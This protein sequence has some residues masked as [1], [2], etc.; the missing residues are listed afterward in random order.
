MFV[1]VAMFCESFQGVSIKVWQIWQIQILLLVTMVT[2]NHGWEPAN[3]NH[4]PP[5][6]PYDFTKVINAWSW[7]LLCGYAVHWTARWGFT[8]CRRRMG[9]VMS[10]GGD[11]DDMLKQ[12]L[13]ALFSF[14]EFPWTSCECP[15]MKLISLSHPEI[16][17]I[18]ASSTTVQHKSRIWPSPIL[19]EKRATT[20]QVHRILEEAK[21][22]EVSEAERRPQCEEMVGGAGR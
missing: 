17:R 21:L 1:F 2:S 9:M 20:P 15:M 13:L 7:Q 10:V 11:G 12:N 19:L 8:T 22:P 16:W 4:P 14:T 5:T 18:L 3:K 6:A